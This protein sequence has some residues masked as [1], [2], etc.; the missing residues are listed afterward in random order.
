VLYDYAAE[1][2]NEMSLVEGEVIEQ[3]EQIDEGWWTAV[4][5][6]GSK[7]GLFPYVLCLTN[8]QKRFEREPDVLLI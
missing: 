5:A 3:V 2:S 7:Q 4:G 6:G 8:K 1:E